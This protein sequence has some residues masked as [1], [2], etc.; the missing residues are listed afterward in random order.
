[1]LGADE[2]S[3]RANLERIA[4]AHPM[5]RSPEQIEEALAGRGLPVGTADRAAESLGRLAEAGVGRFYLQHL[6]PFDTGLLEEQFALL[7]S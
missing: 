7:A 3:F 2:A 4:A 1:M 6:G 5:G